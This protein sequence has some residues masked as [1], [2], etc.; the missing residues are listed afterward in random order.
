MVSGEPHQIV[1]AGDDPQL[2]QLVPVDRVL[3]SKL[4]EIAIRVGHHRSRK[5]VVANGR[6]HALSPLGKLL[7]L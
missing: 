1:I 3:L 7:Q 2:V 6:N 4:G 5:Q